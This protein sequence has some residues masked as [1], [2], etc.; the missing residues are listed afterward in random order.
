V[1]PWSANL[2]FLRPCQ[3]ALLGRPT[4]SR[5][6]QP[7]FGP[8]EF[9]LGNCFVFIYNLQTSNLNIFKLVHPNQLKPAPVIFEF[10][11]LYVTTSPIFVSPQF[12]VW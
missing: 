10:H 5:S 4:V 7:A 11:Y 9:F 3:D 1:A 8:P 6:A 12:I 2:F